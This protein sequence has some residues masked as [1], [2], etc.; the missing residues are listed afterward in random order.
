M[1]FLCV[2]Q[3]GKV[4]A[5][6]MAW[7]L[8]DVDQDSL[9]AGYRTTGVETLKMLCDWADAIVLMQEAYIRKL[10]TKVGKGGFDPRKMIIVDVGP[11]VFGTPTHDAL[12]PY[13][14]GIAMD[15]KKKGFKLMS[16]TGHM[17]P[18]VN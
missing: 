18:L 5:G 16:A 9:A 2:C 4:R 11:D 15:W 3:G 14:R 1:K 12:L 13:V 7:A 8:K 10:E 17:L 6:A